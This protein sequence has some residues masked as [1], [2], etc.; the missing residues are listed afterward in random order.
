L[1]CKSLEE[2]TKYIHPIKELNL[3]DWKNEGDFFIKEIKQEVVKLNQSTKRK[4]KK[5]CQTTIVT[6]ASTFA[7]V[8]PALADS[9][10]AQVTSQVLD[11]FMPKD[12]AVYGLVLIGVLAM[13]ST[14]LAIL[15]MQ[16]AGGLKMLRK[17]KD[18]NEWMTDIMKGYTIVIVSPVL[19]LTIAIVAYLLFG[20]FKWF[21]KPF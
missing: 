18:A 9:P 1:S 2:N 15:L 16:L 4:F 5:I 14:I 6:F 19:I 17:S 13:A 10:T 11:G 12:L 20:N 7:L 21:A 8:T 3:D